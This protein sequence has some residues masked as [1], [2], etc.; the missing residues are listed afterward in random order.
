MKLIINTRM[1]RKYFQNIGKAVFAICCS[2]NW[3]VSGRT[4]EEGVSR[5]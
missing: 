1:R 5:A 4:G 3:Q 2:T